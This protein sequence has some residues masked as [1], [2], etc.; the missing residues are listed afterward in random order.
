MVEPEEIITF[1]IHETKQSEW[2]TGSVALDTSIKSRFHSSWSLA[3]AGELRD[4]WK[5]AEGS[6]GFLILTDQFPRNMFRDHADSFASDAIA[7]DCAR[8]AIAWGQDLEIQP[9]ARQFFYTPFTHSENAADQA[10]N[11]QLVLSRIEMN[12]DAQVPHA[13]AHQAQIEKFGRFPARNK[14]LGRSSTPE[15]KAFLD[16]GGYGALVNSFKK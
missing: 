16:N 15:E 12:A 10:W 8:H 4:W 13:W 1:W 5:S 7:R 14:A 6:L 2:Y 11:V 9:P 3:M